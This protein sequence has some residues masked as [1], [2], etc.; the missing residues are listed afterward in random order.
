MRCSSGMTLEQRQ[1]AVSMLMAGISKRDVT[2]HFSRLE[3]MISCL[4]HWLQQ[5]EKVSYKPTLGR[6]QQED[7]FIMTSS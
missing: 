7:H 2:R 1:K 6:P 4:Q 3:S 5:T